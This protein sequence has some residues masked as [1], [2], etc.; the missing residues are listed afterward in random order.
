MLFRFFP[1]V[2]GA[3][4]CRPTKPSPH[5]NS[6]NSHRNGSVSLLDVPLPPSPQHQ[7][8]SF[9]VRGGRA[10]PLIGRR[11]GAKAGAAN[12][13]P[14]AATGGR[15]RRRGPTGPARGG[16]SPRRRPTICRSRSPAG[17]KRSWV[18]VFFFMI[19]YYCTKLYTNKK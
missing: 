13:G 10:R 7:V 8:W 9:T 17:T 6:P 3:G 5:P 15:A 1:V 19:R 12:Q 16:W 4:R 2:G 14:A 11:A 18:I